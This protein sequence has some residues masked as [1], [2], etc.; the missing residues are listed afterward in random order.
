V[1]ELAADARLR[2]LVRLAGVETTVDVGRLEALLDVHP[3]CGASSTSPTAS[4]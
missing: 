3:K 2:V 1:A 4:C